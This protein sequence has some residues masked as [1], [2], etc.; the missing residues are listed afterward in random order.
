[1]NKKVKRIIAV[2]LAVSAISAVGPTK[3][4]NLLSVK[5]YASSDDNGT[6]LEKISLGTGGIDFKSNVTDYTLQLD[7]DVDSLRISAQPKD[8]E[9]TV[10]INGTEVTES[11]G[12]ERIISLDKGANTVNI[13]VQKR[14]LKR[15]YTIT[16]MRGQAKQIYLDSIS[17][18]AGN[19]NFS[20]DQ[21]DY[22]VDVPADTSDISIRAIPEDTDYDEEIGGV[23]A[24]DDD[25]YK[26][27]V[28]LTYGNNDVAIKI[29]DNDD[30]EKIYT[31]H[32]NRENVNTQAQASTTASNQNTASGTSTANAIVKGWVLNNGA[33]N[34][35]DDK[36][37]KVIGWKQVN[38]AWYYLGNDGAMKT[39]WQAINGDWYYL[40]NSG[41]MKTGWIENSDGK[42]YYLSASGVMEKN[43]TIDGYKLD[44]SGAWI[45]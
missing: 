1:M 28:N 19:I 24:T 31:L 3:Y 29:D 27:T 18:S 30:H 22:N 36:G 41:V 11:D 16:V 38:G 33:W 26:Q 35:I 7:P 4:F 39:G 40:D 9:A 17:L 10:T 34:Y 8:E 2:G 43:T 32:I 25:N 21:T 5:A 14:S 42:W 13:T 37:S 44:V 12:Y 23:T 45:K 20:Q 6:R 15:T